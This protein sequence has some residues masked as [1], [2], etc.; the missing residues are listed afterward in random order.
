MNYRKMIITLITCTL[1]V[2]L[3]TGCDPDDPSQ[4]AV[5]SVTYDGNGNTGGSVPSDD[6][7]YHA[8]DTVTV[9]TN[10]GGLVKTGYAFSGWNTDPDGKGTAFT[11]DETFLMLIDDVTLYACWK[12]FQTEKIVQAADAVSGENFGLSVSISGDYA[13][14]GAPYDDTGASNAGKAYI[15]KIDSGGNWNEVDV[16]QA[17][18]PETS[19]EFGFSVDI[20]GDYVIVGARLEDYSSTNSGTAYIFR[21]DGSD[22]WN[23][24]DMIYSSEASLSDNFGTSVAIFGDYAAVGAP[25]EDSAASDAGAVYI[26]KNNGSDVWNEVDQ[27]YASDAEGCDEFGFSV[28]IDGDYVIAGASRED[29]AGNSSGAAYIFKNDGSDSWAQEGLLHASIAGA[30][31]YFGTS[32]GISGDTAIVGARGYYYTN[33]GGGFAGV[34]VRSSSGT[35]SESAILKAPVPRDGDD[36]GCA[37]AIEGDYA[38]VGSSFMNTSGFRDGAAYIYKASNSGGWNYFMSLEASDGE[39]SDN[40]GCS[41]SISGERIIAGANRADITDDDNCGAVYFYQ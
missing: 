7:E 21:K 19:A 2:F 12:G 30:D 3:I 26:F 10:S 29:S 31:D 13:V 15:Y 34:Y 37:V 6:T 20:N 40:M 27:L 17:S 4:P 14:I 33:V 39:D 8:G 16:L 22:N 32:V 36:F 24:V 38:V 9:K 11:A 25:L 5:F 1:V 18:T 28:D 35:W 23:E 41:V